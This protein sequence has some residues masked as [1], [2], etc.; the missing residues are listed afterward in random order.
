MKQKSTDKLPVVRPD[1]IH[2]ALKLNFI[3]K[4][5]ENLLKFDRQSSV[6][7]NEIEK[8]FKKAS[9]GSTKSLDSFLAKAPDLVERMIASVEQKVTD[10]Q[11]EDSEG[12]LVPDNASRISYFDLRKDLMDFQEGSLQNIICAYAATGKRLQQE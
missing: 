11:R 10:E 2:G 3:I 8:I 1:I 6:F 4:K 7:L 5:Y 12:P 9:S